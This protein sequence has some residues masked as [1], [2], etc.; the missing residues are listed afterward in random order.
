MLM[1]HQWTDFIEHMSYDMF[2]CKDMPFGGCIDTAAH[3]RGQM[4][5]DRD[6]ITAGQ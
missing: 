3:F 5:L 2:S 6:V 1:S 4:V